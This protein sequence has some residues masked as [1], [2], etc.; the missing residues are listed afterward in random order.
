MAEKK[1]IK[2]ILSALL[3]SA[4]LCTC[5]FAVGDSAPKTLNFAIVADLRRV[6]AGQLFCHGKKIQRAP[7]HFY[8]GGRA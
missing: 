8:Q 1:P 3:L 6:G 2:R 4:M 7:C 5:L